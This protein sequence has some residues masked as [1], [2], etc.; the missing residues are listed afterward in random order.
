MVRQ[1]NGLYIILCLQLRKKSVVSVFCLYMAITGCL[2]E[3]VCQSDIVAIDNAITKL[4]QL[5]HYLKSHG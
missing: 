2:K 3:I 1:K 4:T 5:V